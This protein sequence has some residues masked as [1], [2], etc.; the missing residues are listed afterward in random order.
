M[1]GSSFNAFSGTGGF[2]TFE[3]V[4]SVLY[5]VC[6]SRGLQVFQVKDGG[7]GNQML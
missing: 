6:Q 7:L 4:K 3:Y 1:T 2:S 5:R